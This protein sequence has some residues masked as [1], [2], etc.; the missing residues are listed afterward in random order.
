MGKLYRHVTLGSGVSDAVQHGD[1][2][3]LA[4]F[5]R[6]GGIDKWVLTCDANWEEGYSS[7]SMD[8]C[9]R[10][11]GTAHFKGCIDTRVPNHPSDNQNQ[12]RSGYANC[13]MPVRTIFGRPQLY[14]FS[15]FNMLVIRCRGDGRPYLINLQLSGHYDASWFDMLSFKLY[16]HG[17]PYWQVAK[18]PLSRFV[19]NYK[20]RIQNRQRSLK[21]CLH[22]VK[23]FGITQ[24]E[25]HT[26]GPFHLELDYVCM[27]QDELHREERAWE[28]YKT[29][30]ARIHN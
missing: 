20:G 5:P 7:V 15:M 14:D 3:F 8:A 23:H 2:Y 21:E 17:G 25:N 19:F 1:Y 28:E 9:P 26:P 13:R 16:T 29:S 18:I 27:Y 12:A 4:N 11:T 30:M 6:D 22:R 24:A 10:G